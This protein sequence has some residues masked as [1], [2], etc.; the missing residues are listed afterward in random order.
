MATETEFFNAGGVIVTQARFITPQQTFAMAGVTSVR[1]LCLPANRTGPN[2]LIGLGLIMTLGG[3]AGGMQ[4][5]PGLLLGIV[6][7]AGGWYWR[8]GRVDSHVV[9]LGTAGGE[10]QA[11]EST[12]ERHIRA[13]IEAVNNAIIAR[14]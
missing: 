9:R 3:I 8:K 6:T 10:Q 2:I 11:L 14:R 13:I 4:G 1:Y 7:T 5:I 12:D